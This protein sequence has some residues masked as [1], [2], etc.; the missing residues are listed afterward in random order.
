MLIPGAEAPGIG[1]PA[2]RFQG[3]PG[4]RSDPCRALCFP[5]FGFAGKAGG[6]M[7]TRSSVCSAAVRAVGATLRSFRL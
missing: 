7:P 5:S 4:V 3:R 6:V 2:S 1:C